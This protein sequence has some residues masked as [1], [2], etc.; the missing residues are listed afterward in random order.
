MVTK[1][2]VAVN[3]DVDKPD[4]DHCAVSI[5]WSLIYVCVHLQANNEKPLYSDHKD[6]ILTVPF[7]KCYLFIHLL[8]ILIHQFLKNWGGRRHFTYYPLN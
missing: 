5:Y 2:D 8:L 1:Q 7:Y 4:T 6:R 3:E